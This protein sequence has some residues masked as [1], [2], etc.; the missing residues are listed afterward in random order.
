MGQLNHCGNGV[1]DGWLWISG[2]HRVAASHVSKLSEEFS[3][4][5]FETASSQPLDTDKAE[6]MIHR[7]RQKVSG[8]FQK[9]T[10]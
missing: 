7:K 9:L 3:I 5:G 8:L 10:Q 4:Q 1:L 2:G 6:S